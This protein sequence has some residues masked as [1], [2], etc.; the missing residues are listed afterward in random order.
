M[1]LFAGRALNMIIFSSYL[2]L[3]KISVRFR[4][5]ICLRIGCQSVAETGTHVV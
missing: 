5:V 4:D 2:I 1:G 3:Q